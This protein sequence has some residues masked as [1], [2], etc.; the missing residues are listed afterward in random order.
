MGANTKHKKTK[1]KS[2]LVTGGTGFIG[3]H[4]VDSLRDKNIDVYILARTKEN[5]WRSDVHFIWGD[6][7]DRSL[8]LELLSKVDGVIH[9]AG[10]LGTAETINN[11]IPSVE[12]NIL[13]SLNVLDGLRENNIPAVYIA[14]GNYWMN[15]SYSITK[16]TAERFALMYN[17]EHNTQITVIRALNAFGERQKHHPVKKIIPTF[18]LQAL[19]NEP[20]SIYGNGKQKMDMIYVKDLVRIICDVLLKKHNVHNSVIEAGTGK[21][22]TVNTIAKEVIQTTHSKSIIQ[23][24]SMRQ[25]EPK[26]AVVVADI[27]T[28]R[29]LYPRGIR[30]TPFKEGLRETVA[31]Y[32]KNQ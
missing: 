10:R 30:F 5:F 4:V 19:K 21:G 2:V 15:N 8:V 14:V 25:G 32:K 27:K 16:T 24:V 20:I 31:W 13:G 7:R 12:V 17:K 3:S 6:I 28:L 23:H 9:L 18:I 29:Q 11:P 26:N 22:L 1:I